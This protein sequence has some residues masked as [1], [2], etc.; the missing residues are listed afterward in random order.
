VGDPSSWLTIQPGWKVV[1]SDGSKVGEVSLV[2]GDENQDIFNGLAVSPSALG[3][4]RYVAAEQIG[5]ISEGVVRLSLGP[6]ASESLPEYLEPAT[7]A[8]VEP[9]DKGGFGESVK[10][11]ARKVESDL[12]APVEK[13][14]RPPGLLRRIGLYFH[15]KTG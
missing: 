10:A 8:V 5:E 2:T 9:D 12:V 6:D 14:E 1:A 15:R 4:P 11:T 13:H 7:S 3:K